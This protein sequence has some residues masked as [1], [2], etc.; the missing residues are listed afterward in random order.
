MITKELMLTQD[1]EDSGRVIS[2]LHVEDSKITVEFLSEEGS[3]MVPFEDLTANQL[4]AIIR[5]LL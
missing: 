2:D 5:G 3:E 1:P 4:R